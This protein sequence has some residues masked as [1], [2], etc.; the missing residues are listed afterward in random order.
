MKWL[1]QLRELFTRATTVK[2]PDDLSLDEQWAGIERHLAQENASEQKRL[3]SQY[4]DGFFKLVGTRGNTE[5]AHWCKSCKQLTV[6][7]QGK[8]AVHCSGRKR[9]KRPKGWRVLFLQ[10]AF[11]KF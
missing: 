6:M 8:F 5:L 7:E 2:H 11:H 4:P 10:Q 3:E 9:E 1:N